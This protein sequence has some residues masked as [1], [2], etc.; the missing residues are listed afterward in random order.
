MGLL[1]TAQV[2]ASNHPYGPCGSQTAMSIGTNG[3]RRPLCHG[4]GPSWGIFWCVLT[5]SHSLLHLLFW[6]LLLSAVLPG[7]GLLL[8]LLCALLDLC[9]PWRYRPVFHAPFLLCFWDSDPFRF[10][11]AW[12]KLQELPPP[13]VNRQQAGGITLA[14]PHLQWLF[15]SGANLSISGSRRKRRGHF[16]IIVRYGFELKCNFH[17][18][19]TWSTVITFQCD[20]SPAYLFNLKKGWFYMLIKD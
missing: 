3:A 14:K 17:E 20:E 18:H 12:R 4:L 11:S 16:I 10:G 6:R 1:G 19:V 9:S 7:L 15:L 13:P 8:H 5:K 2:H